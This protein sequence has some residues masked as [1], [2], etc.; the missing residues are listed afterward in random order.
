[1]GTKNPRVQAHVIYALLHEIGDM[2]NISRPTCK[3]DVIFY[4][5]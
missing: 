1:V 2:L 3:E 4:P 5:K